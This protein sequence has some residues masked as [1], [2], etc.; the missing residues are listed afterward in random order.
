MNSFINVINKYANPNNY[1][2]DNYD[3]YFNIDNL[4]D[5]IN[6]I[7][8]DLKPFE[9]LMFSLTKE[10]EDIL[11]P[12]EVS[13]FI[14]DD[15]YI[16]IGIMIDIIYEYQ[17][18]N[19]TFDIMRNIPASANNYIDK[20]GVIKFYSF[21]LRKLYPNINDKQITLYSLYHNKNGMKTKNNYIYIYLIILIVF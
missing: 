6:E 19:M 1:N 7:R 17:I 14:I 13:L 15:Y 10:I 18:V 16:I 12:E 20:R 2:Y 3:D 11:L 5:I 21:E 4:N 9:Y 8:E